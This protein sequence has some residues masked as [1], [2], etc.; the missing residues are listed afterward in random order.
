MVNVCKIMGK[1]LPKRS[2][3]CGYGSAGEDTARRCEDD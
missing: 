3:S 1:C 2:D